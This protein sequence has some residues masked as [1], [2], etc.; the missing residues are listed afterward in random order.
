MRT[1]ASDQTCAEGEKKSVS[2]GTP[3]PHGDSIVDFY[4]GYGVSLISTFDKLTGEMFLRDPHTCVH[5][6]DHNINMRP[7]TVASESLVFQ[8]CFKI[9]VFQLLISRVLEREYGT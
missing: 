1:F 4:R 7:L 8:M 6:N 5:K 2:C 9:K 3:S